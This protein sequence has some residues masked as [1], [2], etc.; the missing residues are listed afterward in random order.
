L[1]TKIVGDAHILVKRCGLRL[2]V[3]TEGL[4]DRGS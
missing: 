1:R 2:A 4:H 3:S